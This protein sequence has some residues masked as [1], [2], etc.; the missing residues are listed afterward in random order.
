M[1]L[2]I[3]RTL[4]A[5]WLDARAHGGALVLRIEDI[6]TPRVVPGA[7]EA[8]MEDLRWLGLDWDGEVTWQSARG[9]HYQAAVDH[10]LRADR[11]FPCTC[12]RREVAQAQAAAPSAPHGP[13]DDGP[14]Y[15]GTCR[16]PAQRRPDRPAALRFATRPGDVVHHV[17][18]A[19]G[20]VDQDVHAVVGDFVIRRSDGLWAYQLAVTVDDLAQG[21]T[22]VVRGADLLG[23][24]PRQQVLRAALD[25]RRPPLETLHVPLLRAPDGRRLAKRD[26]DA[27]IASRR[28][29]GERAEAVVGLLAASLGI[30]DRAEPVEARALLEAWR[31]APRSR[32]DGVLSEADPTACCPSWSS[33]RS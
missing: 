26:G 2:G 31:S 12:S 17:D 16:D 11:A 20:A 7:A 6:D 21:V 33:T 14:R 23:S 28:D 22:R 5:G 10:L 1:H 29:R 25:P 13:G 32:E 8:I 4:L 19:Y 18:A 3:A 9:A 30:I 27:G 24:T 15:P